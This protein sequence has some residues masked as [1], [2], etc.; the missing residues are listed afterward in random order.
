MTS[1]NM[2]A[3]IPISTAQTHATAHQRKQAVVRRTYGVG[4]Q[5]ADKSSFSDEAVR[6][7]ASMAPKG[8]EKP[9]S[10]LADNPH[11]RQQVRLT[12]GAMP[13]ASPALPGSLIDIR[14]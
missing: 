5:G 10:E 1:A 14:V 9:A 7:Q 11:T 2:Q 13:P 6:R 12:Y 8:A 3:L 4:G